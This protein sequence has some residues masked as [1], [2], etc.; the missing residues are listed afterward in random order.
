M[1]R[2]APL[3]A[4]PN[5]ALIA[6]NILKQRIIDHDFCT[7]CG[8]CEAAC[9]TDA[10]QIKQNKVHRL[11]DCSKALDLCPICYEICPHSEAL[12]LRALNL[13][14]D[15]PN[16]NEALGYNRKIVI[17]QASDKELRDKSRGGGVA[18]A[19]LSFGVQKK[20]FDWTVYSQ[21]EKTNSIKPETSGDVIHDDVLSGVES[22]YL[23][24]SVS[25]AYGRA[26]YE[27]GKKKIAYV[28]IPCHVL[29]LR[30][31]EAWRHK[32][33]DSLAITI[34]LFCFGAFSLD[35]VLKYL[36]KE[37]NIEPSEIKQMLLSSE[38]LVQTNKE[39][40]KIPISEIRNYLRPGCRTCMDYTAELSDISVG[41]A[42]PLADWS[43]VIIRTKAG[44]DFFHRAVEHG[45]LNSTPIEYE[46]VVFERVTNAAIQ[47][48]NSALLAAKNLETIYGYLPSLFLRETEALAKVKVKDIM[49]K[50]VESVL[51]SMTVNELLQ[52]TAKR[53]HVGY[54]VVDEKDAFL[55][56]VTL[57]DA[58]Q[59]EKI[60]RDTTLVSQIIHRKPITV[61]IDETAL[62][63]FKKMSEFETGRVLVIDPANPKKP[64]GIVTKSDL[65]H[66]LIRE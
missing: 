31:M 16:R 3:Q 28:G 63:A 64:L 50:K 33:I 58:S 39:T 43:T 52:F 14:S 36:K 45:V 1:I 57:E 60:D 53:H 24:A 34:G 51:P 30:K 5:D 15:A 6:Y 48:R 29:A 49:T 35:S 23:I 26:V 21:A 55:G 17:A 27:S 59:V 11:H 47:K 4:K 20:I 54:P 61:N 44:E 38:F 25:K 41:P 32:F 18:A 10:L 12:I 9:P 56:V 37:Y 65:M 2:W 66:T 42:Y 8:A 62:D 40:I 22:K 7:L 19:L 13:I 46:P